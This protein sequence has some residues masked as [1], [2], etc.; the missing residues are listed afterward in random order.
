MNHIIKLKPF[1]VPN[2]VIAD[3]PYPDAIKRQVLPIAIH[4]LTD[5]TLEEM[6]KAF[7]DAIFAKKRADQGE[8]GKP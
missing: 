1:K 6:C 2:F 4:K 3:I 8:G 5:E 7:R